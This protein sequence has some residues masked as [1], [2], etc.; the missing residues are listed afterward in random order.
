MKVHCHLILGTLLLS[1]GWSSQGI[2]FMG[3]FPQAL[4]NWRSLFTLIFQAIYSQAPC[5]SLLAFF[6][7]WISSRSHTIHLRVKSQSPSTTW[8]VLFTCT[9]TIINWVAIFLSCLNSRGCSTWM[10]ATTDWVGPYLLDFHPC[11]SCY[12]WGKT[13]WVEICLWVWR[14]WAFYKSLIS[15]ATHWL[16]AWRHSF[17]NCPA[18]SSSI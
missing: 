3:L 18:Y 10:W 13:S 6:K 1:R 5:R 17:M 7:I 12:L 8:W 4:L 9:S 16:A 2:H 14:V 11:L 15:G